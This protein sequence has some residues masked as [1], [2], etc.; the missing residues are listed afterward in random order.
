[1]HGS[2]RALSARLEIS[3]LKSFHRV[4]GVEDWPGDGCS[5]RPGAFFSH[6]VP[7]ACRLAAL[8]FRPFEYCGT[9]ISDTPPEAAPLGPDAAN[10]PFG[11]RARRQVQKLCCGICVEKF[12]HGFLSLRLYPHIRQGRLGIDCL[13]RWHKKIRPSRGWFSYLFTRRS[14]ASPARQKKAIRTKSSDAAVH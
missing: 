10:A 3:N 14:W 5:R 11:K 9:G 2:W 12:V 6:G 8:A 4:E 1:M 7:I 13:V